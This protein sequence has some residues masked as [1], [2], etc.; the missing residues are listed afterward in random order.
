MHDLQCE[1]LATEI[2][3]MKDPRSSEFAEVIERE[4]KGLAKKELLFNMR[5]VPK[6]MRRGLNI[7]DPDMSW[8][9]D[10]VGTKNELK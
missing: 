7:W 9:K 2:I 8:Q 4:N 10:I 6:D 3:P 1:I 5:R